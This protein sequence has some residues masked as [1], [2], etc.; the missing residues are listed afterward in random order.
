M[1]VIGQLADF[2]V[3]ANAAALPVAEQALQRRHVFDAVVAAAAGARTAEARSLAALFGARAVPEIIGQRAATIRLSEVDD[4]H[5][6]SCTT[7]S[8]AAVATALSLAAHHDRF[9]PVQ[10]AS[11]IWAGTE[12]MTR[13]GQAVSGPGI[14]YL[15]GLARFLV[16]PPFVSL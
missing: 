3:Q 13:M 8:A 11:A 7:P 4:I 16:A 10:V 14:P 9:D 5:L 12:L 15:G 1:T 2:V 6:P